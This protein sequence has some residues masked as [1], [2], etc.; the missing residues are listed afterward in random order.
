MVTGRFDLDRP[1]KDTRNVANATVYSSGP[2]CLADVKFVVIEKT[3]MEL[4]VS[5]K[6]HAVAGAAIGLTDWADEADHTARTRQLIITCLVR[7]IVNFQFM[8]PA[9]GGL[10]APTRF[11]V[12]YVA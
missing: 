5:R 1:L 7:R 12:G 10:D 3:Q 9:H 11:D 2:Q 6:T 8:Q 4:A